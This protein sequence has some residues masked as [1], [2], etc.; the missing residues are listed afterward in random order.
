[1]RQSGAQ[2]FASTG[3][4][5][6]VFCVLGSVGLSHLV[7]GRKDDQDARQGAVP[8]SA[9]DAPRMPAARARAQQFDLTK[10]YE[11]RPLSLGDLRVSKSC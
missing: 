2:K 9:G 8:P 11:V 4:P 10:E 5:L 7:Q 3:V 6:V 1:M